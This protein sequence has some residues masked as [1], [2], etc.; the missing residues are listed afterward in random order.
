MNRKEEI[1]EQLSD[2]RADIDVGQLV[3]EAS[4]LP[5]REFWDVLVG[6]LCHF[7]RGELQ[8]GVQGTLIDAFWRASPVL[9]SLASEWSGD[10]TA[11][12]EVARFLLG[13]A[14]DTMEG[15]E[16]KMAMYDQCI[17]QIAKFLPG[18][19]NVFYHGDRGKRGSEARHR[20]LRS[21]G[22]GF[23]KMVKSLVDNAS[24]SELQ[25][26]RSGLREAWAEK[27]IGELFGKKE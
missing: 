14:P 26:V 17:A 23:G 16:A 9:H 4:A 15:R 3:S 24:P 25:S 19:A 6:V 11:G 5:S 22:E 12:G 27:Q 2:L 1:I 10:E 20:A 8:G 7:G 13:C 21:V 18:F